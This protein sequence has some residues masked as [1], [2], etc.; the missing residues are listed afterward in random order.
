MMLARKT[1]VPLSGMKQRTASGLRVL[2]GKI[3][4]ELPGMVAPQ[5]LRDA[6]RALESGNHDGAKRHLQSAMHTMTPLS[7]MRHGVLDDDGHSK[8]KV[9]MD[10]I[11]RHYLLVRDLE[12]GEAHNQG[13]R[14]TPATFTQP[15]NLPLGRSMDPLQIRGSAQ[16]GGPGQP[17]SVQGAMLAAPKQNT[18]TDKAVAGGPKAPSKSYTQLPGRPMP[19]AVLSWDD[20]DDAILMACQTPITPS[21]FESGTN[22]ARQDPTNANTAMRKPG[23]GLRSTDAMEAILRTISRS[24]SLATMTTTDAAE[25]GRQQHG[26][27]HRVVLGSPLNRSQRSGVVETK[28]QLPWPGSS[29]YPSVRLTG[30][31]TVGTGGMSQGQS[32]RSVRE[33]EVRTGVELSAQTA[34]LAMTPNPYGKSGGPG[35]YGVKGNKHSD[36]FENIVNALM[37]KRG[38]DKGRASAIAWGALRRWSSGG[39][40]VHPE[41]RA[42]AGGALAKEQVAR[43]R[44]HAHATSWDDVDRLIELVG[45]A[46]GAAQVPRVPPG[47][48]SGGQFGAASG[49]P[50]A[51]GG[52]AGKAAQ[53]QQ[54]LAQAAQDRALAVEYGKLLA[55]MGAST[56]KAQA[57]GA[58]SGAKATAAATSAQASGKSN[59]PAPAKKTVG[60]K[61]APTLAQMARS[62]FTTST[63]GMTPQKKGAWLQGQIKQ[64]LSQAS[65]LT[66]QAAKL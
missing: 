43:D 12:D 42:A 34:R 48:P 15:G 60:A 8:A 53:K 16:T 26:V 55:A 40:H 27:N 30:L 66:A 47:S 19:Q 62:T 35:L 6:A 41:V 58:K 14:A 28:D 59:N 45:T 13:L 63:K 37:K 4:D 64:L 25:T 21:I 31:S 9:N 49:A 17:K 33:A 56:A 20:V 24:V 46:A 1:P 3:D 50:A 57:A 29:G 18:G 38:M 65:A 54:L 23:T 32:Q 51:A 61:K 5:H 2:A 11:N 52:A 22:A 36:Y 10:L 39:G 44:A 7:L